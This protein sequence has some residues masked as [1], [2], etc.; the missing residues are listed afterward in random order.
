MTLFLVAIALIAT[1]SAQLHSG[2]WPQFGRSPNFRSYNGAPDNSTHKEWTYDVKNKVVASPAVG[3][4]RVVVGQ[5]CS[6][7]GGHAHCAVR[8][9]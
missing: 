6:K 2:D 8:K 3:D 1:A 7:D 4:G 5:Y 9:R